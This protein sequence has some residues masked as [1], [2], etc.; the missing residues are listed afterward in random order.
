L[1]CR[2]SEYDP[3]RSN[4]GRNHRS[5]YVYEYNEVLPFVALSRCTGV[6]ASGS[7]R[8]WGRL[9]RSCRIRIYTT[10]RSVTLASSTKLVRKCS[11]CVWSTRVYHQIPV[12]RYNITNS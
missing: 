1:C 6:V 5:P 9:R 3:E 11:P 7:T 2:N 8:P 12:N 4:S 10:L